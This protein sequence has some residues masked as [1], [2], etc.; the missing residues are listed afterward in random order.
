MRCPCVFLLC[1]PAAVWSATPGTPDSWIPARW[2]GGP[3]ELARRAMAKTAPADPAIRDAI[4]SWYD[5]ATL[6]LLEGSPLNCLLVTWS[7]GADREVERR[8]Q[9]LIKTYTAE[10][11]QRGIAVLGLVYPGA[12]PARSAAAAADARLDG[13][14]L[15]GEFPG[16]FPGQV[17]RAL[18]SA[19]SSAVVIPIAASAASVRT[20]RRPILAVE[21]VSPSARNLSDMGIT[22]APSSEPWIQS[23]VWLVRSFRL[24]PAWRPVW[25]SYQPEGGTPADYARSVADAAVAGGRWIVALDDGLRA[26]LRRNDAAALAAWHG[27]GACLKF[28]EDHAEWRRF[29]PFGNL[30][31]VVDS[32]AADPEMADEYLK[33]VARRQ[34][35]YRLIARSELSAASL[36]GFRAVLA[37]ALAPPTEVERNALRAFAEKGGLVVAGPTWGDPPKDKPFA[38]VPVGKGRVTVY[39]DLDPESVARD[40][41][42]LLSHRDA[43]VAAFNVPTA[44]TY[45]STGAAGKCLLVQLLNYSDSPATAITIRVSGNFKS[46]RLFTPG[47]EPLDLAMNSSDGQVDVTIPKLSLWGGVLLE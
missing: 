31:I 26:G 7:A 41:R 30:G 12:D 33:L 45:A 47:A 21:G 15:D 38:E 13:L 25:I 10:A 42:D 9:Q 2:P 35:P 43:G 28:A 1:L 23:N 20:A 44:I 16:G 19:N 17:D 4:A 11:H 40:M 39:K 6:R 29:A 34:A 22:S 24:G 5:P 27:I 14:A 3:L 37:T 46:A 36:A 32:A 8:Q 18:A